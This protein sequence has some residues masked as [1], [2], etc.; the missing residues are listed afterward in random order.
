MVCG[1][2]YRAFL[3]HGSWLSAERAKCPHCGS[4]ET[5]PIL[6]SRTLQGFDFT[7][8]ELIGRASCRERV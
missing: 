1:D 7:F 2:C 4:K 8:K 6:E 3:F 5:T